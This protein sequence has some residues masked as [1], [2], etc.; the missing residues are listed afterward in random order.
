MDVYGFL[1]SLVDFLMVYISGVVGKFFYPF[2][3]F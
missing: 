1:V 3:I 2:L